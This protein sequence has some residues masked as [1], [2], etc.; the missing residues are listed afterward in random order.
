M[1]A[2]IIF[3]DLGIEVDVQS[4]PEPIALEKLRA[5]ELDALV[6][7]GG[8]PVELIG[9][10]GQAEPL[11]LLAIPRERIKAA[12]VPSELTAEA[13]PNL[14]EPKAPVPTVAVSAVLAAYNWPEGHPRREKLNRFI[15]SFTT[16]FDKLLKP[17]FHPKWREIDLTAEVPGWRRITAPGRDATADRA[18]ASSMST[19]CYLLAGCGA[20]E[21]GSGIDG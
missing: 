20:S 21:R 19:Q 4:A 1:T 3:D 9:A 11:H 2:G 16:N 6:F 17:P 12:Y 18:D 15:E 10:I 14:I 5:G 8:K 7:V 13:Y